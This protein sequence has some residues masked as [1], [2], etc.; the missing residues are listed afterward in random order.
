MAEYGKV[1]SMV[2]YFCMLILWTMAI[3]MGSKKYSLYIEPLESNQYLIKPFLVVGLIFLDWI[4]YPYNFE[5]DK[6]RIN[7]T[8]IIY[9]KKF[10]EYYYQINLAEKITYFYMI[11]M[12]SLLLY[13]IM[14]EP[15]AI[16]FG[17]GAALI[18]FYYVDTKI[19]SVV[20]KHDTEVLNS[21]PHMVSKMALLIN[22]GMIMSEA[23][24]VIAR[25]NDGVLY[26]EMKTTTH[27]I[28]NG[29][30]EID[31]YIG[32]GERCGILS[33][34]KFTSMMVQ[35]LTKGNKELTEFLRNA[36]FDSW[37]EK[38]HFV[39][40]QGEKASNKLMIPLGMILVGIF[41]MILVPVVG[42]LGI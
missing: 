6:K 30:P 4:H 38:K 20:D 41:I 13:P 2:V 14:D 11:I 42:N 23:W 3:I 24:N 22:A 10:A 37:E 17:A 16:A 34:K 15:M 36:S 33:V 21:F 25:S 29:T 1:I 39:K 40:R 31:A 8:K 27:D 32:F 5:F 35:N 7:Q 28:E 26:D 12:L 9:G 18:V 19:V